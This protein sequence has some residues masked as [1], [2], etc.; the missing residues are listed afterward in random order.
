MAAQPSLG[1]APSPRAPLAL[2]SDPLPPPFSL[3]EPLPVGLTT[4]KT[5]DALAA[6]CA[7]LL[8][9]RTLALTL[10]AGWYPPFSGVPLQSVWAE[11]TADSPRLWLCAAAIGGQDPHADQVRLAAAIAAQTQHRRN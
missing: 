5:L 9:G 4:F 11:A 1:L 7:E 6:K 2:V 10:S 8:E 3:I